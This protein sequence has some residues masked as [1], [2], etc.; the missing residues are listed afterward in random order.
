M[1][2][3]GRLLQENGGKL[4]YRSKKEEAENMEKYKSIRI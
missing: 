1:R 3:P 4:R 2:G